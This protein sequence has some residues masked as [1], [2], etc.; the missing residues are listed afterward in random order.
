MSAADIE[1]WTVIRCQ[2]KFVLPEWSEPVTEHFE[3]LLDTPHYN[4]TW[5]TLPIRVFSTTGNMRYD[6]LYSPK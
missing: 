6:N 2:T 4:H 5:H 1:D 3:I